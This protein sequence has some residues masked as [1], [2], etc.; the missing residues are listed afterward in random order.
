M[1][2]IIVYDSGG[3]ILRTGTCADED[4]LLQ[5]GNGEFVMEGIADDATQMIVNG[6]IVS[7]PELT[8]SE[9][10]T[11]ALQELRE[12]R[13]SALEW[14]DWTQVTDSPLTADQ[15]TE[16]QLYRQQLRDLPASNANVTSID[17]VTFPEAPGS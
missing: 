14:C 12:M 3:S 7:K 10:N 15:R 5:A 8:D 11:A 17:D 9:K 13:D 16:W 2:N 6:E 1:K 4:V